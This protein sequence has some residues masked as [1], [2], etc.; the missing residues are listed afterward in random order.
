[1]SQIDIRIGLWNSNGQVNHIYEL[2]A[3]LKLN[4]ID[5]ML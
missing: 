3:F 5:I 4:L 1:M 2:E